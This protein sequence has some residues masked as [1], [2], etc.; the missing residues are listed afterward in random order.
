MDNLPTRAARLHIPIIPNLPTEQLPGGKRWFLRCDSLSAGHDSR[1]SRAH[2]ETTQTKRARCNG[3]F[4]HAQHDIP[5]DSNT[6][7][8]GAHKGASFE[9]SPLQ[10]TVHAALITPIDTDPNAPLITRSVFTVAISP[11]SGSRSSVASLQLKICILRLNLS[12]SL[13]PASRTV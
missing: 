1:H 4:V 7:T 12:L 6:D 3:G 9:S 5:I 8:G 10:Q 13:G 2:N 11:T